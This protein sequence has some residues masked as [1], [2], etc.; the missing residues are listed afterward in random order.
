MSGARFG[1]R[2]P[3]LPHSAS[4][5][6]TAAGLLCG[7]QNRH[8][9]MNAWFIRLKECVA[10][11]RRVIEF[12]LLWIRH[13]N[14]SVVHVKSD[15]ADAIPQIVEIR[16]IG[17]FSLDHQTFRGLFNPCEE[18]GVVIPQDLREI[19]VSKWQ[20]RLVCPVQPSH[21]HALWNPCSAIRT[22]RDSGV[23]SEGTVNHVNHHGVTTSG[24]KLSSL[25]CFQISRH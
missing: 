12:E 19:S 16:W 13:G 21:R 7:E 11:F 6:P 25:P 10:P 23:I 1:A 22:A 14:S 24:F 4:V 5:K 2:R 17:D 9:A 18:S 8:M 3:E 15:Q 20:H